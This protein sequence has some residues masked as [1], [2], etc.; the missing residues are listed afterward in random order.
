MSFL[1][2]NGSRF[3]PLNRWLFIFNGGT[4]PARDERT[5]FFRVLLF[6]LF[7][8]LQNKTEQYK[9]A[10]HVLCYFIPGSDHIHKKWPLPLSTSPCK[11]LIGDI[12][13]NV[14][15]NGFYEFQ[16]IEGHFLMGTKES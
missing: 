8:V 5:D 4:I 13:F 7:C 3:L 2:W 10:E 1:Q 12:I 9:S 11:N 6:V 15:L 16:N 14:H